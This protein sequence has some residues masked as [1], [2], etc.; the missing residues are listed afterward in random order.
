MADHPGRNENG[1]R[2][3]PSPESHDGSDR[4]ESKERRRDDQQVQRAFA[5]I[6]HPSQSQRRRAQERNPLELAQLHHGKERFGHG[7]HDLEGHRIPSADLEDVEDGSPGDLGERDVD[8]V[9]HTGSQQSFQCQEISNHRKPVDFTTEQ[10]RAIIQESHRKHT[11]FGNPAQLPRQSDSRLSRAIDEGR[12][13]AQPA[14][15]H[16]LAQ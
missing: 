14:S 10:I 11:E 12:D 5:H 6:V 9:R 7:R 8:P 16:G 1:F 3:V 2:P 4:H 15:A 13:F